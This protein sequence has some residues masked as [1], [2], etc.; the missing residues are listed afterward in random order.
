MDSPVAD[1]HRLLAE[2]VEQLSVAAEA[3]T[4]TDAEMLSALTI[5]EGITR[6]LDRLTLTTHRHAAAARHVRRTRLQVH[7]RRAR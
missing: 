6:R 3:G 2:A 1:A 4:A 5:C 7:R